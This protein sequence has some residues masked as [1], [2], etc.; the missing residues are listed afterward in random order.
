MVGGKHLRK[1]VPAQ[2][3]ITTT[4]THKDKTGLMMDNENETKNETSKQTTK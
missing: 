4:Q 1:R 3:E 2:H